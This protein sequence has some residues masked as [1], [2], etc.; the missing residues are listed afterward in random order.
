MGTL[1][2][3]KSPGVGIVLGIYCQVMT[4]GLAYTASTCLLLF[5]IPPKLTDLPSNPRLLVYQCRERRLRLHSSPKRRFHS[6]NRRLASHLAPLR[7]PTTPTQNRHGRCSEIVSL[8]VALFLHLSSCLQRVFEKWL[9]DSV[10]GRCADRADRGEWRC[11]G[12][13]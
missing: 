5:P 11:Y 12:F 4:L 10:L 6:R 3:I 2:I 7:L 1:E 8:R 13:Q 9:D